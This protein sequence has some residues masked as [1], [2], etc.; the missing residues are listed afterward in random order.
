MMQNLKFPATARM[1]NEPL[2][3]IA[4]FDLVPVGLVEDRIF[5]FP[6]TEPYLASFET[7]GLASKLIAE[8]G[9]F[10]LWIIFGNLLLVLIQL[11]FSKCWKRL[12]TKL[13]RYL[14]WNGFIRLSME[15]F[16]DIVLQS[17]INVH[18]AD[19]STPFSAEMYSNVLALT[20]LVICCALPVFF[21]L[22]YC[23][24]RNDWSNEEFRER[25]GV[26]LENSRTVEYAYEWTLL[27]VPLI[28]LVRRLIL[29]LVLVFMGDFLWG[30]LAF[31]NFSSLGM[32]IFLQ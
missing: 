13:R 15:A 19:W 18:T 8:N 24:R 21:F 14:Y 16:F 31:L 2:V 3:T 6:E 29:S 32:V 7:G 11:A 17:I 10:L 12:G 4:T 23:K 26:V 25:F 30:Q 20:F 5:Y 9:G 1:L 27:A 22:F 28:F